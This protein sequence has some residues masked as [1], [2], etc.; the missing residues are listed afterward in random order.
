MTVTALDTGTE[1]GAEEK[2]MLLRRTVL[3]LGSAVIGLSGGVDSALVAF[4][5]REQLG[6]RAVAVTAISPSLSADELESAVKVAS[7]IGI[8]HLKVSTLEM[9]NEAYV[10]NDTARCF[11]C[12]KELASVLKRVAEQEGVRAVLLGVNK[13]DFG[14]FRPGIRAAEEEGLLFPLAA[15]G[16]EKDDVRR[17]ARSL[18]LSVHSK[19]SNACLSSRIQYGQRIELS[20]LRS[21]EEAERFLHGMGFTNVRVR[22]H[23]SV[24]RLE[25]DAGDMARIASP[26]MREG[27]VARLKSLGFTYVVLDL[28][29]FRSGSMNLSLRNSL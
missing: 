11:H 14:D 12:K 4:I 17:M 28:E 2:L 24:A 21:V 10:R 15:C 20:T 8:R 22:V 1:N 26:E 5:A 16:I 23:G 13:S 19:P 3:C 7:E 25:V 9:E 6:D 27:I 18:G 29:G